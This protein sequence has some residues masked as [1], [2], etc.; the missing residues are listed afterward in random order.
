MKQ[1]LIELICLLAVVCTSCAHRPTDQERAQ[2]F[3]DSA[4]TLYTAGKLEAAKFQL[5]S[6]HQNFPK[7]V[8]FRRQADTL[9]WKIELSEIA[10]NLV[11]IDSLLPQKI[12]EAEAQKKPFLFEK[13]EKFQQYGT[14]TYRLLRTEWNLERNYMKPYTDEIGQMYIVAHYCGKPIGYDR[15]RLSVDD[16]FAESKVATESDKNSF[17]DLGITHETVL[18]R[19]DLL[20]ELPDFWTAHQNEKVKVT[21]VGK[22][23]YAYTLTAEELQAFVATYQLATTLSDIAKLSDLQKRS[24][25]REKILKAKLQVVASN[26]KQDELGVRN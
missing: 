8:V 7:L 26:K 13:N 14:Y 9:A 4:Q 24:L 3:L 10:R 25:A 12:A 19:A 23:N 11:Y 5:D 1:R 20:G 15:I 21:F 16:I 18:F 2:A 6:V 22:K 17:T